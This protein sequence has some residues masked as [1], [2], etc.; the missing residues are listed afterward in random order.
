MRYVFSIVVII[1]ISLTSF[2]PVNLNHYNKQN[3][4]VEVKGC[5]MEEKVLE[6][7]ASTT[8]KEALALVT[9]NEN[10][11]VDGLNQQLLL[12]DKDVI[13]I[14]CIKEKELISINFGSVEQLDSL[15]GIGESTANKIIEY[16]NGHGLFQSLEQLMEVEGIKEGKFNAI[17]D[18]ICL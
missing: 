15:P 2:L 11:S 17:K 6:L 18:L 7:P 9:L 1:L 12:L 16:R 3:I 13:N 14:P 5:V 10:A 4:H 8:I